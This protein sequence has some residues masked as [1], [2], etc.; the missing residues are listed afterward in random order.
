MTTLRYGHVVARALKAEGITHIFTLSGQHI[1][2]IYEGCVDEGISVIDCR[3]EQS[4][5]FAAEAWSKITGKTGVCLATAG[6][7]V[8]NT[9]TAVA[10]AFRTSTPMVIIGGST[11]SIDQNIGAAQELNHVEY[12]TPITK[13]AQRVLSADQIPNYIKSAFEQ[14]RRKSG[15]SY[16]DIPMDI[17]WQ[18]VIG[19]EIV[20]P[21]SSNTV[22][23]R[24][25][26]LDLSMIQEAVRLLKY[27][28]RPVIVAGS[29]VWWSQATGELER[30]VERASF[31]VYLI[32]LARGSISPD[33][34]L[35]FSLNRNG[36]LGKADVI[37]V[38][39][40]PLDFRLN[41]GKPPVFSNDA[42]V[43][44]IDSLLD[45]VPYGRQEYLFI[46]GDIKTILQYI[47]DG[48]SRS[49]SQNKQWIQYLRN[50]EIALLK[51]KEVFATSDAIPIHPL[52]FCHEIKNFIGPDTTIIADGGDIV[53]F[54]S[55]VVQAYSP[56]HWFDPGPMGTLGIGGGYA[57]AAKLLRPNERVLMISGD[58]AFGLSCMEFDTMVRYGINAVSI[59]GN[60]SA[61][62]Q[63]RHIQRASFDREIAT[64]LRPVTRYD[65]LVENLGGYGEL[66]ETPSEIRPALERAFGSGKPACVN[67]IIDRNVS[68]SKF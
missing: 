59:I 4:A 62:G 17:C 60:D 50:E 46:S 41:Y 18:E 32:S 54:A 20:L 28:E 6:P 30:L 29:G 49:S 45:R 24:L 13:S 31:P 67:V 48:I 35:L 8:A 51:E 52:R 22:E 42:K 57:L 63:V 66:V 58:G 26:N 65:L 61:W 23:T 38:I 2:P 5:A 21:M 25:N 19:S 10:N 36:A 9:V 11:S 27:A 44:I 1:L 56:G 14:A 39:G 43:I 12:M 16:I 7:G 34:Q 47:T 15:P 33:N 3:H 64:N 53:R 68:Y 37:L 55:H 40:T